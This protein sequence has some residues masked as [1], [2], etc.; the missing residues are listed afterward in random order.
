MNN[1]TV[2][3]H[4]LFCQCLE[5]LRQTSAFSSTHQSELTF[6]AELR[7]E[8]EVSRAFSLVATNRGLK[9]WPI[10]SLVPRRD[11]I[12][13]INSA[14]AQHAQRSRK[15]SSLSITDR[16]A[17]LARFNLVLQPP[18]ALRQSVEYRRL[19]IPFTKVLEL[20]NAS[21]TLEQGVGVQTVHGFVVRG[22][23]C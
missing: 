10:L 8:P 2:I 4:S 14:P 17:Q 1:C 16:P 6:L 3:Q 13:S 20:C 21:K 12:L 19:R 15:M 18:L 9:P 11:T 22:Q 23:Q 7:H 5:L